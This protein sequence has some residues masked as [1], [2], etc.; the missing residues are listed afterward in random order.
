MNYAVNN[1]LFC[2]KYVKCHFLVADL[3]FY[4]YVFKVIQLYF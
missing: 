1:I 3:L 4:Q 2:K